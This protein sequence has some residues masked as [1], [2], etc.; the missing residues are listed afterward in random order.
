MEDETGLQ[1]QQKL[2]TMNCPHG[3]NRI[4]FL[5]AVLFFMIPAKSSGEQ[6]PLAEALNKIRQNYNRIVDLKTNIKWKIGDE[7][8][9]RI[10][11]LGSFLYKK[12]G[13][14]KLV[15]GDPPLFTMISDG[16]SNQTLIHALDQITEEDI[17]EGSIGFLPF[18]ALLAQL[19]TKFE[20]TT[21]EIIDDALMVVQ[22]VSKIPLEGIPNNFVS[23]IDLE[24]GLVVQ[25][26]FTENN[27]IWKQIFD[28]VEINGVNVI[29]KTTSTS[30]CFELG[31]GL[32]DPILTESEFIMKDHQLNSGVS[33]SNISNF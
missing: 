31:R 1:M 18:N 22:F 10:T 16:H 6:T 32:N 28:Y 29:R 23:Y 33:V 17:I 4:V 19:D 2:H 26:R 12:P 7:T 5:A 13:K 25:V 8:S 14:T 30:R 15:I 21:L 3:L 20:A 27:C 9:T 24:R 11:F